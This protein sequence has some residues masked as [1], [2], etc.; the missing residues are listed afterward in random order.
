MSSS[1]YYCKIRKIDFFIVT[2][3][4]YILLVHELLLLDFFLDILSRISN[5]IYWDVL[6][7]VLHIAILN[8]IFILFFYRF[9]IFAAR[10][11]IYNSKKCL[12][13]NYKF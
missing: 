4:L 11:L 8:I 6:V 13:L 7:F 12:Y 5:L 3:N 10:A 9:Q 2:I 1:Y